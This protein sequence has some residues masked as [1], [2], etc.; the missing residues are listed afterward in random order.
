MPVVSAA[1]GER[2]P[3]SQAFG[4]DV[5]AEGYEGFRRVAPR[6]GKSDAFFGA[7]NRIHWCTKRR[8]VLLTSRHPTEP[9]YL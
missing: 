2:F 6:E 5:Y 9:V 8:E 1:A 3:Y 7:R 4:P